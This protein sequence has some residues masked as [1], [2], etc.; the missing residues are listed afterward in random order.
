MHST[1]Y[2]IALVGLG[3]G[4]ELHRNL[5]PRAEQVWGL[6]AV[7]LL[8]PV[9]LMFNMHR[10]EEQLAHA[11]HWKD[12]EQECER[13]IQ[14]L[15]KAAAGG[16]PVITCDAWDRYPNMTPY[17]IDDIVAWAG[18][19]YFTSTSTYALAYAL[20]TGVRRVDL[21][22]ITGKENYAHQVPC[23]SY[24]MG[25]ARGM[26]VEIHTHGTDSDLLRADPGIAVAPVLRQTRY[27]YDWREP[28]GAR[29]FL[30]SVING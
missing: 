23:L 30:E 22:G 15:D 2:H 21:C 26:G 17:P 19:D 11:P 4:R 13:T 20:F 10:I 8:H 16:T 27:G 24:W 12:R 29:A 28:Y 3:P 14:S 9:D 6:N 18:I 1:P 25:H 7:N 5:S